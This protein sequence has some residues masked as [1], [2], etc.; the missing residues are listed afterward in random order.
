MSNP[1]RS[2]HLFALANPC[3]F[4]FE[5]CQALNYFVDPDGYSVCLTVNN[6]YE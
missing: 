5:T 1:M 2:R 6:G 4:A 3:R